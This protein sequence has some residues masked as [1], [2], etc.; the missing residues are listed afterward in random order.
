M[1]ARHSRD[2][3]TRHRTSPITFLNIHEHLVEEIEIVY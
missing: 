1:L 2:F 3:D